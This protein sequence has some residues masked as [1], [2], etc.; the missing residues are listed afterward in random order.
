MGGVEWSEA[1]GLFLVGY[2]VSFLDIVNT[3]EFETILRLP[4]RQA[5]TLAKS[6]VL[7]FSPQSSINGTR[8][9]TL[10]NI[11]LHD[12]PVTLCANGRSCLM[13]KPY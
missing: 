6:R 5:T 7:Q 2:S 3:F 8:R 10:R 11:Q 1:G 12:E 13:L 4:K 9:K